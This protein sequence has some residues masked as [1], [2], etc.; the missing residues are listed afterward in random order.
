[1]VNAYVV[2]KPG[3]GGATGLQ[4]AA[5]KPSCFTGIYLADVPPGGLLT[6]GN[7]QTGISIAL[8]GCFELPVHA[9][10]IQYFGLGTTPPCCDYPVIRDPAAVDVIVVD[11]SFIEWSSTGLPAIFNSNESCPCGGTS[12]PVLISRFDADADADGVSVSWELAGDETAD[13]FTLLRRTESATAPVVA[14]EGV[15]VG[16]RGSYLDEAVE[17]ATTYHY[18]LV[19][20]TRGGDEFR[21]P[22]VKVT[23]PSLALE[24]GQNHPNPFNPQTAIP[25]SLPGV[26]RAQLSIIDVSGKIVRRLVDETQAAGP[27]EAVWDGKDDR[28][29]PVSSGVYFY[30][31]DA[32]GDRRTRKLVLLK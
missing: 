7:S 9:L 26:V 18:A 16:T 32:N 23:T 5:P 28:G 14:G 3:V 22:E 30:V 31:L 10:T 19:V 25:Y 11:C 17:P 20:R 29:G 6:I 4:F 21:S 27:H 1:L 24:L 12:V 15:V 13:R 8:G 2:V